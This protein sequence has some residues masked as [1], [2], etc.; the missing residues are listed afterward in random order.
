VVLAQFWRQ[1]QD[2][3]NIP[4]WGPNCVVR[5][6]DLA[7]GELRDV[8]IRALLALPTLPFRVSYPAL[9][10]VQFHNCL[11]CPLINYPEDSSNPPYEF[12][13]KSTA[14][15]QPSSYE[16]LPSSPS[17]VESQ[18]SRRS[19][20]LS[21][22]VA[23]LQL[24]SRYNSHSNN[25]SN[26]HSP[27]LDNWR[28]NRSSNWSSDSYIDGPAMTQATLT[29]PGLI[30]GR[31]T[32]PSVKAKNAAQASTILRQTMARSLK[33][34]AAAAQAAKDRRFRAFQEELGL[35][36]DDDGEASAPST[37]QKAAAWRPVA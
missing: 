25:S 19:S 17:V 33:A 36:S 14:E 16:K 12:H 13:L 27:G 29:P 2:H 32:G 5:V 23:K 10:L 9:T 24:S 3:H 37:P 4:Y 35:S 22:S 8:P 30:P 6:L 1:V 28:S 26:P 7:D 31:V 21:S 15:S 11:H 20:A 34:V 18:S